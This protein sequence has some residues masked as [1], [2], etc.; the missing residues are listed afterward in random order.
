MTQAQ[1]EKKELRLQADEGR[2]LSELIEAPGW[3][4]VL[5]PQLEGLRAHAIKKIIVLPLAPELIRNQELIKVVNFIFSEIQTTIETGV[6]A[7]DQLEKE[8]KKD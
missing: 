1:A 5:R 8:A 2:K 6:H 7:Q 4:D 3:T